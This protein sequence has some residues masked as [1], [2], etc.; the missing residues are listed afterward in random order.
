VDTCKSA[1]EEPSYNV[2]VQPYEESVPKDQDRDSPA[3]AMLQEVI[4]DHY[5]SADSVIT[6]FNWFVASPWVARATE[7]LM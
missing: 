4:R 2:L 7:K 3:Y 1:S 6:S 5:I